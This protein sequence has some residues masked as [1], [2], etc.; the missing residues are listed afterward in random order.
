[1]I[2]SSQKG[3]TLLEIV[4]AIALLAFISI[5]VA[6]SIRNGLDARN[7]IQKDI[8]SSVGLREA[9]NL[10]SR[11]IQLA[12]NFRDINVELYNEALKAN[13]KSSTPSGGAGA[14]GSGGSGAGAGSGAG[15]TGSTAPILSGDDCTP[16]TA[17]ILTQFIGEPEKL[18]LA[19]RSNVRTQKDEPT[20]DQ[21][22]VGYEL[23][24]CKSRSRTTS[25]STSSKCLWR[26]FSPVI[27]ENALEGGKSVPV[28]ENV[29][30]LAFRYLGPGEN[31]EW[32]KN[33]RTDGQGSSDQNA[34]GKFPIAVEIT[35]VVEDKNTK[36]SKEIGM[37]MVAGIRF[38]N[39]AEPAAADPAA[40]GLSGSGGSGQGGGGNN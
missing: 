18:N 23:K 39:N 38:P 21:A 6:Q 24:D 20:S 3:F 29:K 4:I 17:K 26:R 7:K 28:L 27:D 30:S 9:L 37:T 40:S 15:G 14:G 12:F 36:P 13:C 16:K 19:T 35:M 22:E 2:R 31:V 5:F 33:W 32:I 25:G 10:M 8:D 34:K 1:M 11:D